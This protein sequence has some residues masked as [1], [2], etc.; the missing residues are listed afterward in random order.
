MTS[1]RLP[2]EHIALICD[3]LFVGQMKVCLG[4]VGLFSDNAS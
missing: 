2:N 4:Y 1:S 3:G